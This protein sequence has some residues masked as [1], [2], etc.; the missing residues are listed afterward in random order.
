MSTIIAE[1]YTVNLKQAV[2]LACAC[3]NNRF[4]F[5]GEP[6]IG[7]TSTE[8]EFQRITGMHTCFIDCAN[9]DLGDAAVP[10]PDKETK[11]LEYYINSRFGMHNNEP[12]VII[13]DEFTKAADPVKNMLHPLLE[14]RKPRLGSVFLPEG[15]IVVLTGNLDSD[16]VGDSL[17]AHTRMRLTMLEISKPTSEEW[18]AWA[19]TADISPVVMAWVHRNPHA[20]ASYRDGDQKGNPYIFFP[21]QMADAVVTP[22]TLELASNIVKARDAFDSTSLQAALAG[23]V[24]KAAAGSIAAFIAHQDSLPTWESIMRE[25]TK[26]KMPESDGAMAVLVFGAIERFKHKDEVTAFL[27]Y[28]DRADVEWQGVFCVHLMR[29]PTKNPLAFGCKAFADWVS[30]NQDLL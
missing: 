29:S 26:A 14:I 23:T 3:R 17:L 13:L 15:S 4:A 9:L 10:M 16:G 11:T 22:R 30:K 6:G 2:A 25:P 20:L 8:G 1:R 27:S 24:G 7:K 28:M 12:V 19:S 5:L 21:N 18:L